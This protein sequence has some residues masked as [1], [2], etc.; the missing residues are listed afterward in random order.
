MARDFDTARRRLPLI[1]GGVGIAAGA[2]IGV[3]PRGEEEKRSEDAGPVA[4]ASASATVTASAPS[5][6]PRARYVPPDLSG[7][8]IGDVV[9]ASAA[10]A[11]G[12]Y[13]GERELW[14]LTTK[15][16]KLGT[17]RRD[18]GDAS[19]VDAPDADEDTD[20]GGSLAVA[21]DHVFFSRSG[22]ATITRMTRG[23]GRAPTVFLDTSATEPQIVV[24]D[25]EIWWTDRDGIWKSP[26]DTA[27][28]RRVATLSGMVTSLAAGPDGVGWLVAPRTPDAPHALFVSPAGEGSSARRTTLPAT[29]RDSLALTAEG[30]YYAESTVEPDGSERGTLVQRQEAMAPRPLRQSGL[31]SHLTVDGARLVWTEVYIDQKVSLLLSSALDG[32]NVVRHGRIQGFVTALVARDGYVYWSGARGI[33]RASSGPRGTMPLPVRPK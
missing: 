9:V 27:Q 30:A 25:R 7:P 19:L 24:F 13:A 12:L 23:D 11:A 21:P 32:T 4:S 5:A 15:G 17:S 29:E 20:V 22:R 10:Y 16:A 8:D 3:W 33:E 2:I 1:V 14:W 6:T 31:I 26:V 18:G 28:P